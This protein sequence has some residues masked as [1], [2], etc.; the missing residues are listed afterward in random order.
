MV[1]VAMVVWLSA[2]PQAG[3]KMPHEL[4][5]EAPRPVFAEN[6]TLP[7]LS[8]WGWQMPYEAAVE[9]C[10]HWGYALEFGPELGPEAVRQ[11]LLKTN[12]SPARL[13]RLSAS[14]PAKFPLAV[15]AYRGISQA[16]LPEETFVHDAD[17]KRFA[18]VP[19]W[20]TWSP[21]L[22]DSIYEVAAAQAAD[23]LTQIR[24]T[25]A[26]ISIVLNG[27][28]YG[29]NCRG[30]SAPYWG[31]DP[32]VLAAKGDEDW[33]VWIGK[34]KAHYEMFISN[35]ARK[36]VPDRDL[37]LYYHFG[38]MPGWTDVR[39]VW[40]YAAMRPVA[41]IPG[42]MFYY[43]QY[44]NSGWT[45][46][47]DMLSNATCAY[48][49]CLKYGDRLAYHWL[50]SGWGNGPFSDDDR[51]MGFLKCLYNTGM[52]GAVAGYFSYPKPAFPED[53]GDTSPPWLRQMM[54]LGDAH[55]LFSHLETFI[56]E[57]ELLPGPDKHRYGR[58]GPAYEFPTG[59]ATA[60]VLVRKHQKLGQWLVTAWAAEGPGREV[61]VDVPELGPI[62][63][64]ARPAG[65]V[66]RV[67]AK[68]DMQFEPPKVELELLDP[69]PMHPSAAL[70]NPG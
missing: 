28:E 34:R 52:I 39:W 63:V 49:E 5:K 41:D 45:G 2:S 14:N 24:A 64:L 35:A 62:T 31:A 60:R 1:P 54:V 11:S 26:R 57:G 12:S 27:G 43:S 36:A 6:H 51:Y 48:H 22:P 9:L 10:E 58:G 8:R 18:D 68:A 47:N 32:R 3:A 42:Q 16:K 29:L 33:D 4:L 15:I 40:D 20:K 70:A 37:Y 7:P 59:D 44:D 38:A 21:L 65:S 23:S 53:Q 56:R 67:S 50:C 30:H 19:A 25:G 61:T 13:A 17:G 55:A 46:R 66:Y 69:D